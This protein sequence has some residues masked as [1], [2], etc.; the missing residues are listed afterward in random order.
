MDYRGLTIKISVLFEVARFC[1]SKK[2]DALNCPLHFFVKSYGDS[3]R[4]IGFT[5]HAFKRV[6]RTS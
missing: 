3:W 4:M 5:P 6:Y 2:S 1:A